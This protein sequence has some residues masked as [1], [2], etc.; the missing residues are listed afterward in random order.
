MYLIHFVLGV[1][2]H[3]AI[4]WIGFDWN[5]YL[6]FVYVVFVTLTAWGLKLVCQRISNKFVSG[7]GVSI[8][9]RIK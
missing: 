2:F 9:G 6:F 4:K 1:V 5:I 8:A 3:K 7:T